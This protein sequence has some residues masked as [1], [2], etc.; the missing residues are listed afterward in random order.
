MKLLKFAAAGILASCLLSAVVCCAGE[1]PIPKQ[2]PV[3]GKLVRPANPADIQPPVLY[4]EQRSD[5]LSVK[6]CGAMGDGVADDTDAIQSAYSR[7]GKP[8][9]PHVVYFPPGKYRLTKTLT[10]TGNISGLAFIGH[11]RDSVLFWD[12]EKGG[13]M[14]WSNGVHRSRYEGLTYDG[15]GKAGIGS[16]HRSMTA[17]ETHVIYESCAFLNLENGIAVSKNKR[18]VASAEIWYRNCLFKNTGTG[19][20]F[21]EFND[22]DNWIDACIFVANDVGVDSRRGHFNIRNSH[23]LGSHTVD[24][25]QGQS[26]HPSS[27]RWCTSHGSKRFF[28]TGTGRHNYPFTLQDNWVEGWTASDGAVRL[29]LRGPTLIMDNTF[30]KPPDAAAP[31]R[32]VNL[33]MKDPWSEAQAVLCGNTPAEVNKLADP[34]AFSKSTSIPSGSVQRLLQTG[35]EWFY[36]E[37][38]PAYGKVFDAKRDFHASG[39][40]KKDDSSAIQQT[41]DAARQHGNGAVAYLPFGQY[42]ITKT[43]EVTGAD[44]TIESTGSGSGLA[45]KGDKDGV[46]MTVKNPHNLKIAHMACT[47]PETATFIRQTGSDG[48]SSVYYN[49]LHLP[50]VYPPTKGLELMELPSGTTVRIGFL[51][52][53][54]RVVDSGQATVL[55]A[56]KLGLT[57]IEGS[58]LPKTGFMG[59]LYHNDVHREF[60]LTVKDNQDLV[61]GDFYCE[62]NPRFLVCEGGER[63]EPGHVTIGASKISCTVPEEMAVV[64]NYEGRICLTT[65]GA[66][67]EGKEL[68]G[69][70]IG[71]IQSGTR[72]VDLIVIA[73]AFIHG[74]QDPV[75]KLEKAC[76]YIG[77]ENAFFTSKLAKSYPD[78]IPAGGLESA[79]AALDDFRRLGRVNRDLNYPETSTEKG[80]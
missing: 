74:E 44:Y 43:L 56:I 58:K 80:K 47:A 72:P 39:D 4:Q 13:S 54:M 50:S 17:Y 71:F 66:S 25:R 41:V 12:G 32:F 7:I 59:L 45:W 8:N 64:R 11:G 34:G 33:N 57:V 38:L 10:V 6:D 78:V 3:A 52:G 1:N 15:C 48:N 29:G 35:Q 77:I 26:C 36:R 23:F 21:G 61:V 51:S 9:Q 31:I 30:A 20:F 2:G 14:Y 28:E 40:G 76:R 22:Y 62:Q 75:F 65:G 79:A 37:T 60:A 46:M 73:T 18:V 19:L 63:R 69:K 67:G 42:M 70:G 5:W 49:N 68:S 27:I 55:G 24:V 16:E 53:G